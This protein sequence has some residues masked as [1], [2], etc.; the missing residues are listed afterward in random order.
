MA[1]STRELAEL[2]GTT[3]NSIRHYHRLGLLEEPERQSNG[4]KQYEV[5]HL[6]RLLR[7]R[8]LAALGVPLAKMGDLSTAGDRATASLHELDAELAATIDRLQQARVD[9]AT[10]LREQA[11]VDGPAGFEPVTSQLSTSD[12]SLIH[13]YSQLYD[14]DALA[15]VRKMVETDIADGTGAEID[16]LQPDADEET[17]QRLADRLVPILTRNLLDYPWLSDPTAHLSKSEHVTRQTMIEAMV[18]LYNP[19]QLDVLVRASIRADE[20]VRAIRAARTPTD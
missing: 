20:Q 14:A 8:R 2:A 17:R 18:E 5:P 3:V 11:P 9:I 19:A 10:I 1:W 15:D 6:V 4:Y 7:I 16:R 12:S 13:I